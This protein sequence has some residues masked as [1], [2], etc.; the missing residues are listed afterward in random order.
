VAVVNAMHHFD[1]AVRA[2]S[3]DAIRGAAA[4]A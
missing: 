1:D 3:G 2:F 4:E